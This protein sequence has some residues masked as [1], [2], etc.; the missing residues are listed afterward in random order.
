MNHWLIKTE[1]G[2]WSWDDQLAAPNKTTTW[3]G[4]RNHQAN[5]YMKTMHKGDLCFFYHSVNQKRIVG[6]VQVVRTHEPDPTD[7]TGRGFGMVT[8]KAI[9]PMPEP[10]TLAQIKA[11]PDLADMVLVRNARL[12]VQPVTAAQWQRICRL[13]G[14]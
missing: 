1:P 5:N 11:D 14:L 9:E 12:S 8:V 3:D 13:G 10:V 7:T 4:V 6:I 2:T